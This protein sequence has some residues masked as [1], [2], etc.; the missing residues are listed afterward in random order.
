MMKKS[1]K[2]KSPSKISFKDYLFLGVFFIAI[3]FVISS[4]LIFR[5]VMITALRD[6]NANDKQSI[7]L[8]GDGKQLSPNSEAT[9]IIKA[10]PNQSDSR[11]VS[12]R[13]EFKNVT[14]TGFKIEPTFISIGACEDG[15]VF[16]S[17]KICADLG[18]I[19]G[20]IGSNEK[21]GEIRLRFGSDNTF[22]VLTTKGNGFYNGEKLALDEK[23][24]LDFN[25]ISILPLTGGETTTNF[26][27]TDYPLFIGITVFIIVVGTGG[28]IFIAIKKDLKNKDKKIGKV[29]TVFGIVILSSGVLL[30]SNSLMKN[31]TAPLDIKAEVPTPAFATMINCPESIQDNFNSSW[32]TQKFNRFSCSQKI[33][34]YGNGLPDVAIKCLTLFEHP[35]CYSCKECSETSDSVRC[36]PAI[37]TDTSSSLCLS[38]MWE[39]AGIYCVGNAQI[40]CD[41]NQKMTSRLDFKDENACL[42]SC[43]SSSS[44]KMADC[45]Q[46]VHNGKWTSG[47]LNCSINPSGWLVSCNSDGSM[48]NESVWKKCTS[49]CQKGTGNNPDQCIEDI[50]LA[51]K[52][53]EDKT[54]ADKSNCS[55]LKAGNLWGGA[56]LYCSTNPESYLIRCDS[57]GSNIGSGTYCQYGC[58]KMPVGQSDRCKTNTTSNNGNTDTSGTNNY[59]T[60]S[61][62]TEITTKVACGKTGCLYDTDCE[63][64]VDNKTEGTAT[65]AEVVGN[66]PSKQTCT[67]LCKYGY[68]NNNVCACA[69]SAPSTDGDCGPMDTNSDKILNYIDMYEFIKVYNKTCTNEPVASWTCGGQDSNNDKVIDYKDEYAMV[70]NYY[71]NVLDCSGMPGGK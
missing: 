47:S 27:I 8:E 14:V 68:V 5:D 3:V 25:G 13:L 37:V 38:N 1:Q 63:G 7:V 9:F 17:N 50:T 67:K 71:P 58:E 53:I 54:L 70:V 21:L 51:N 12:L 57:N 46:I 43:S 10:N 41:G 28:L 6:S 66:D 56:G 11:V 48:G 2:M 29:A 39:G 23:T 69:T 52:P 45:K 33:V 20:I 31:N 24:I 65:C 64:Y 26:N 19:N 30:I 61:N 18:D 55:K 42:A 60:S 15:N 34:P 4:C 59:Q 49:G 62:Q 35:S 32:C 40:N 22:S 44:C 16:T 36:S